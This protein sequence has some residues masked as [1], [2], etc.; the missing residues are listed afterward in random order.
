M[1]NFCNNKQIKTYNYRQILF[2]F[3]NFWLW[4][5][6]SNSFRIVWMREDLD[7]SHSSK[8]VWCVFVKQVWL[9]GRIWIV[10][11]C[12][13]KERIQRYNSRRER[14]ERERERESWLADTQVSRVCV[15]VGQSGGQ[16]WMWLER[17]RER[18]WPIPSKQGLMRQS[19]PVK[20]CTRQCCN[21]RSALKQQN[22]CRPTHW[23]CMLSLFRILFKHLFAP[24]LKICESTCIRTK[25][26]LRTPF[27]HQCLWSS[28]DLELWF[29]PTLNFFSAS[30]VNC[31]FRFWSVRFVITTIN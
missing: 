25:R 3:V 16:G 29:E 24:N 17:E 5:F 22:P 18:D 15:C 13:L 27:N 9:K 21:I 19:Q 14:R 31:Q 6:V 12:E 7:W 4:F 2:F 10:P 30:S 8:L 28:V 26:S 1:F 11:F 20:L 23:M